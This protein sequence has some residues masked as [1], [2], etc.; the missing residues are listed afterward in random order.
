MMNTGYRYTF[1][2]ERV[3]QAEPSARQSVH[4]PTAQPLNCRI[5][6]GG[7]V[8]GP[9]SLLHLAGNRP[10]VRHGTHMPELV[11]VSH[12]ADRLD[13]P[14][15]HVQ[16]QRADDL[17][18]PITNDRAWLAV[19]RA[20]LHSGVDLDEQREDRDEDAGHVVGTVHAPG[21][22]R[23]LASAICDHLDVGSEQLP[24]SADVTI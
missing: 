24:K 10:G 22:R 5:E 7:S 4:A 16:R 14:A 18:V 1:P 17:A 2:Q 15:E 8:S 11:G 3:S 23:C 9:A 6:C 21:K 20:W 12:R 19:Q 13:T